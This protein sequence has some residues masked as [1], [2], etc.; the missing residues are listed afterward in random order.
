MAFRFEWT[1]EAQDDLA[2]LD[3]VVAV[4]ILKKL[5]WLCAQ[6]DPLPFLVPLRQPAIGDARFRIGD[7]RVAI[8]LNRKSKVVTIAAVGHRSSIYQ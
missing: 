7:Y 1:A 6:D 4:R 2:A 5:Q 8:L 3:K